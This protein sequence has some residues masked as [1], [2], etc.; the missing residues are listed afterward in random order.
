MA[1][2]QRRIEVVELRRI[3]SD[4]EYRAALA[5]IEELIPSDDLESI[6]ELEAWANYVEDYE[7]QRQRSARDF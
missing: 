6:A 1:L 5:R 4:A 2:A 3:T 7:E